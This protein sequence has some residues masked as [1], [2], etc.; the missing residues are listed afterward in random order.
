MDSRDYVFSIEGRDVKIWDTVG[1]EEPE[2]GDNGY[3]TANKK[4]MRSFNYYDHS[5][6]Y[7]LFY[8][9]LVITNLERE[10]EME[11]WWVRNETYVKE[12]GIHSVGHACVTGVQ[13]EVDKSAQSRTAML[14]L[15]SEHYNNG[16]FAMPV[17]ASDAW[18]A[19]LLGALGRL[20]RDRNPPKGERMVR[21]LIKRCNM[22]GETAGRLS[23]M[24]T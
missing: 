2:M 13:D 4:P 19:R 5:S 21:A 7:Q 23:S 10:V 16:R 11:D 3:L 9:A 12:F 15:L 22:D 1:L 20:L 24:I 14:K 17:A 8:E 6:N 18:F